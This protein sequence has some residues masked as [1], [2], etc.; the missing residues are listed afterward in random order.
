MNAASAQR[1][2]GSRQ[3]PSP[4]GAQALPRLC[5]G[6]LG[7]G[8]AAAQPSRCHRPCRAPRAAP[9]AQRL[10][11]SGSARCLGCSQ[12]ENRCRVLQVHGI[13]RLWSRQDRTFSVLHEVF[14]EPGTTRI[15]TVALSQRRCCCLWESSLTLK[16]EFPAPHLARLPVG[17]LSRCSAW[18]RRITALPMGTLKT[19]RSETF[20]PPC[21]LKWRVTCT[22]WF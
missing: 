10:Q 3:R 12:P 19:R 6:G 13:A 21:N 2:A 9:P 17:F 20:L 22:I 1:G 4:G 14:A 5:A 15:L 11:R 8:G 16:Q 18:N 7:R